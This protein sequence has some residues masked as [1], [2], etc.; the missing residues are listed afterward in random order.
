MDEMNQDL[1]Q[2]EIP[3]A[4][5]V[6]TDETLAEEIENEHTEDEVTTPE[7]DSEESQEDVK[8]TTKKDPVAKRIG[9]L[10]AKLAEKDREIEYLK[11]LAFKQSQTTTQ[12]QEPVQQRQAAPQAEPK[13]SD[14]DDMDAYVNAVTEHRINKAFAAQ[15]LQS[16]EAQKL[17]AYNARVASFVEQA[18]DFQLA[19]QELLPH[20]DNNS[21][22]LL[23]ESDVGPQV[24]Y[25]LANDEAELERFSRMSSVRKVA[26][27]ANLESVLSQRQSS[28]KPATKPPAK[29][30]AK[31][32][33][34]ADAESSF[35]AWKAQREAEIRAKKKR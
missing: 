31:P 6:P 13:F 33:V 29:V 5:A 24:I 7:E 16:S 19:A 25:K 1:L 35:T 32:E 8:Q 10:S 26:Y 34:K 27:L 23:L 4:D 9:K 14:F 12:Y 15:Q 18:P 17:N 3:A 11:E 22:E 21:Y 28:V 20:I 2:N 30:V